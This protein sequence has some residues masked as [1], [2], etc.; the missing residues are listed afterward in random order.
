MSPNVLTD[1]QVEHF[2]E[3]GWVKLERAYP[4]EV[5]LAAQAYVW[6]QVEKR[7]VLRGDRSTWTMPMVRMNENYDTPEFRACKTERLLGA[8]EDLIGAGQWTLRDQPIRWGWW[9]VNFSHGADKPWDVPTE[10]WHVDGIHHPQYIDSPEQGL[11]LLCLFSDIRPKGGGT[12]VVEGS[13][14]I[15]A[16]I[17]ADH[18]D[19]LSV[20]EVNELAKRHPYLAELTGNA[21]PIDPALS[22]EER[23]MERVE[24]DDRGNRLRVVETTGGPGDVIIGHPFLFHA[25]SP[26]HSGVPRFMCNN[27]APLKDR[28]R[29]RREP[30]E[31]HTPLE[32]SILRA[33]A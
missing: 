12:L 17:L 1:A 24:V 31:S 19:G 30:D 14:N 15:V 4:A 16:R 10:A 28:I 21:P 33:L 3:K 5:A 2:M 32:L 26:N 6:S 13:H 27:Q 9:P 23:F 7:D 20:K 11:L 22:R 25:A 8:I 29:L 18:P